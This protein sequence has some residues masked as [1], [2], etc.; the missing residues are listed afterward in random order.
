MVSRLASS[1]EADR[2]LAK[3]L[4]QDILVAVWRAWPAFKGQ[5]STRTYVARIAHHRIVTHIA[6]AVGRP[7]HVEL[8]EAMLC[9][10]PTPE[11]HAIEGDTGHALVAAVLRLPIAY[12]EVAV[13]LLEGLSIAEVCETLGLSQ[14]AVSIRATRARQLLRELLKGSL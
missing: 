10:N 7:R 1:H 13:L 6:R 5:C 8:P 12:R 4:A 14:N 2:E 11:D 3:D 9:T